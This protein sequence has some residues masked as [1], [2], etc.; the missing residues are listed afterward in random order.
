MQ[1]LADLQKT[2]D[3]YMMISPIIPADCYTR[4]C[5]LSFCH[6]CRSNR[7][8]QTMMLASTQEM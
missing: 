5:I 2:E 8:T 4:I 3:M 6:I 7:K 1:I